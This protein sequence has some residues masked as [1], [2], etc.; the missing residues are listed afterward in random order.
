MENNT[1]N[2]STM[3]DRLNDARRDGYRTA[4]I[5][6]IINFFDCGFSPAIIASGVNL[7]EQTVHNILRQNG[8]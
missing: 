1:I 6:H 3:E 4:T 8:Y 7:T 2:E 5:D